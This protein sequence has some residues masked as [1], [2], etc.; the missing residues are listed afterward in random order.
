MHPAMIGPEHTGKPAH[1]A[2]RLWLALVAFCALL[3]IVLPHLGVSS[4]QYEIPY[5]VVS[6]GTPV[7]IL[8][9]VRLNRPPR[10]SGWLTLCIGQTAYAAGDALS[11]LMC[12]APV[13][14]SSPSRPTSAI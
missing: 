14:S 12:G 4:L 13:T 1:R 10:R 8:V 2:W 6:A 7:I 5:L 3:R 9:G 11:I